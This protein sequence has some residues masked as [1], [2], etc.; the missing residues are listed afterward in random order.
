MRRSVA[1]G[2]VVG[3]AIVA[4]IFGASSAQAAQPSHPSA[5]SVVTSD[6]PSLVP[7]H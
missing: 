2:L 3:A 5:N 7:P 4:A 1:I 6:S